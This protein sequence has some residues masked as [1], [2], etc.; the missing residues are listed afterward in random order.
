MFYVYKLHSKFQN[1]KM[2]LTQLR[3][4]LHKI[5]RKNADEI[6]KKASKNFDSPRFQEA[7]N[8]LGIIPA[9]YSIK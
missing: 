6:L 5:D 4:T 2:D 9:E 1:Y 8:R 3:I 7:A